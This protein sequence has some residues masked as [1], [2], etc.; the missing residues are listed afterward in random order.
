MKHGTKAGVFFLVI[1]GCSIAMAQEIPVSANEDQRI[2][3]SEIKKIS[4]KDVSVK[5]DE[6]RGVAKFISGQLTKPTEM[7]KEEAALDF[8]KHYKVI[9]GVQDPEDLELDRTYGT[10]GGH[11]INVKQKK[12]GLDVIGG[13]ITVRID[14]GIITTVANYFEPNISTKTTPTLSTD[15]AIAIAASEVNL[16]KKDIKTSLVIFLWETGC[17]PDRQEEKFYPYLTYKID[18]PFNPRPEPSKYRI[19]VDAHNGRIVLVE[20]RVMHDGAAVGTGIGVDNKLKTFDTYEKGGTYF[21]GNAPLPNTTSIRIKTYTTNNTKTL[22][23]KIMRDA[24]NSWNDPAG[25]D[26]HFYGNFVF[27]F[28]KNNF[29]NFFW[30]SGSGFDTSDGLLSTV[31]Y[32]KAYDNAFWNGTQM[33][34]GDGGEL[35]HPLSGALDVVAHEITHGVTEAINNLTYCKEP[36]ALNES[37]SDVM[38]MFN[39]IDYGDDLPYLLSEEIVKIDETPGNEAYYAMRRMDDPSFRSDSYPENDYDPNDPLNS[40]GQP[41]HTSEQYNAGCFPWTDNGGVHINSGIPNK[42]AYL[43]TLN[44]NVGS[45]KAKQIYYYAMFYLSPNSQFVDA[46]DAVEQATKDIYGRGQELIAVQA[47]FDAVGIK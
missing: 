33:V 8:I 45:E 36:G 11:F 38:G 34:Y 24:D 46:R 18:F 15:E 41:E 19:Y 21:L 31:H 16:T 35:F 29:S 3:I 47:A 4:S 32:D 20:N 13:K 9:F 30:F 10:P 2:A 26:A 6:R 1:L 37:W 39:S 22:P 40:W 28:Y 23:G 25:V 42:A 44:D 17:D 12:D 43:I 5:W 14:K 27:D 7:S